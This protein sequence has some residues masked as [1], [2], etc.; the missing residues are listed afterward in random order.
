MRSIHR[1]FL[2]P[3][4]WKK[5]DK[6]KR[7]GEVE[8]RKIRAKRHV[9]VSA[10]TRATNTKKQRRRKKKREEQQPSTLWIIIIIINN[11]YYIFEY[12]LLHSDYLQDKERKEVL[13]APETPNMKDDEVIIWF[14][15]SMDW[16]APFPSLLSLFVF[17]LIIYYT[18]L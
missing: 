15:T 8:R 11:V 2:T 6:K 12:V 5:K 17:F 16:Y 14:L 7:K 9:V 1:K 3:F 10:H 13:L 4:S 18:I